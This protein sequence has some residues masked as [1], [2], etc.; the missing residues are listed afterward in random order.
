MESG[1]KMKILPLVIT[2]KEREGRE[3]ERERER[4]RDGWWLCPMS[5]ILR[6]SEIRLKLNY[7]KEQK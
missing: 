5:R 1:E 3:R 6:L 4:E 2:E 7:S